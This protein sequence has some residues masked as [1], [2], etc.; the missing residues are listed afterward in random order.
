MLFGLG[1]W[2]RRAWSD[3]QLILDPDLIVWGGWAVT[4]AVV[5][6]SVRFLSSYYLVTLSPPFCALAGFGATSLCSRL[7]AGGRQL[8][9]AAGVLLSTAAWQVYIERGYFLARLEQTPDNLV[10]PEEWTH[11]LSV[12]VLA[13]T[14]LALT[15]PLLAGRLR[16]HQTRL[17]N[18][19]IGSF[20]VALIAVLANPLAWSLT[21]MFGSGRAARPQADPFAQSISPRVR[22]RREEKLIA[23]LKANYQGERFFLAT[24]TARLAAPIIIQTGEPVAA[25]GGFS[26]AD[27]IVSQDV[28]AKM[29]EGGQL[30]FV[31][32]GGLRG[33]GAF[34]GAEQHLTALSDWVRVHGT[35]VA[36]SL[37]RSAATD[38]ELN[39]AVAGARRRLFAARA[40]ATPIELY[41]LK[42]RAPK[43]GPYLNEFPGSRDEWCGRRELNPHEPL[44][45]TDFYKTWLRLGLVMAACKNF[46]L[47]FLHRGQP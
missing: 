2:V 14:M 35:P 47:D 21:G 11:A 38:N 29:V 40:N 4:S 22:A 1:A 17:N 24:L 6:S 23:F 41:D 37:W 7:K 43:S 28:L 31:I 12:A 32:T 46:P 20:C 33:F 16:L 13:G 27:P 5:Y 34:P 25:L 9:M 30:R 19:A 15:G 18:W 44:S 42:P 39:Y 10:G 8:A 36:P 45:S 3:S 26:G